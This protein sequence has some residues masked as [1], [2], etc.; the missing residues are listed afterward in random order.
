MFNLS[1]DPL[2]HLN[3]KQGLLSNASGG[4]ACFEGWVRNH[5]D[6]KNVIALEYE[7]FDKLCETEAEK[8]FIEAQQ[9]FDVI[10][11]KCVHRTGKLK[12]GDMAVWVGVS[13]PHRDDAFKACRYIIDEVKKRLPIWKKE[14]YENGDSGWVGCSCQGR[15]NT[16]HKPPMEKAHSHS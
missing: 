5:N 8:I 4:F 9:K 13:A 7:A 6:G 15:K 12:V 14:Y 2:E 1:K 10:K 16:R 3:L 11:M